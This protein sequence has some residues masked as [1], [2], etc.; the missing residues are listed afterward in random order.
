MQA[1]LAAV[2]STVAYQ[3]RAAQAAAAMAGYKKVLLHQP[4]MAQSTEA[5]A[6]A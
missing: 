3:A 6:V 5:A 2:P 1:A 4:Q